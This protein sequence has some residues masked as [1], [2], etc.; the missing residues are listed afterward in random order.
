MNPTILVTGGAGYIGSHTCVELL[1]AGYKVI[2]IDNLINSKEE[3][4]RRVQ[5]ITGKTLAFIECDL[6]DKVGLIQALKKHS[7]SAVIHFAGL[8]AVGESVEQPL[9]YYRNNV[10]GTATLL[11][12]MN[13]TGIK[14][15][16]FS[17]SCTVYGAPE[18][19]PI[20]EDFPLFAVNP[21]GQT[22]LTIE[23]MLQDLSASD[24]NWNVSILRYFNP[25]GAHH[26]GKIGEDPMGIPNNLMPYIT[27]VAVGQRAELSVFGGDY[28]TRDGTCI[29]DYIHVVDLAKGH[30]KALAKL[31]ESP[32]TIIH[33]LGT[34]QGYSVLE[35][36]NAFEQATGKEIPYKIIARR[37]GDT[38]AVYAD[39][40]L[41]GRELNWTAGL[42]LKQMC[43]D[44]WRWQSKNP[45]GY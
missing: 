42:G 6:L 24:R 18:A 12:A 37:H 36:I 26:S 17:S 43:E 35:M 28:E 33:N 31:K 41:A 16:V 11:E 4:L 5:E 15:I 7:P 13:E 40:S 32:G 22:K 1:E 21:Y 9:L 39:S 27:Q 25:V 20:R 23:C 8:K 14:N 34:G 10:S 2:A 44:A 3:S 19:L 38:T 30:I 45:N 29:R